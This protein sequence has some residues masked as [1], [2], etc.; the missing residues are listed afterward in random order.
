MLA[1]WKGNSNCRHIQVGLCNSI[2]A[3]YCAG[4]HIRRSDV[5]EKEEEAEEEGR[6]RLASNIS[7]G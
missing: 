3:D 2:S 6:Q 4:T 1:I 7:L 5:E